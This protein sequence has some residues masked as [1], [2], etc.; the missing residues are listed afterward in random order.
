MDKKEYREKAAELLRGYKQRNAAARMIE[1]DIETLKNMPDTSTHA[2]DYSKPKSGKTNKI[3][4]SVESIVLSGERREAKI[5][6]LQNKLIRVNIIN[7][8][9]DM[10]LASMTED[11]SKILKLRYI[12]GLTWVQVSFWLDYSDSYIRRDLNRAALDEFIGI[13]YGVLGD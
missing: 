12:K 4:S 2:I 3:A 1:L 11:Y 10:I 9:I 6:E 8:E 13:Y 5:L 7:Q